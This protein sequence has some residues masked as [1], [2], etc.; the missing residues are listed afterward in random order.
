MIT[1][2]FMDYFVEKFKYCYELDSKWNKILFSAENG[3]KLVDLFFER[4]KEF[5]NAFS[6]NEELIEDLKANI[7]DDL[8]SDEANILYDSLMSL[9]Y[10]GYDDF[11]VLEIVFQPLVNYY[12][13]KLNLNKLIPLLHAYAY[14]ESR[15]YLES[16][17]T[18][19]LD[20][21]RY[22]YEIFSFQSQYDKITDRLSRLCFFKAYFNILASSLDLLKTDSMKYF[23]IRKRALGFWN[24]KI[25]QKLDGNDPEFS[26]F[27]DKIT[28]SIF[29]IDV[30]EKL[31]KTALDIIRVSLKEYDLSKKEN[32]YLSDSLNSIR[33]KL[34][35]YDKKISLM[36]FMDK[37]IIL[38]ENNYKLFLNNYESN[39]DAIDY[40]EACDGAIRDITAYYDDGLPNELKDKIIE[41]V[42]TYKRLLAKLP[43]T[44]Y[45]VEIN[46]MVYEFYGECH[47]LL[48]S[49]E[50]KLD[51]ILEDLMHRQAITCIHSNMV[52]NISVD[53][54]E[55]I[56][57]KKPELFIGILD[58][59]N[60][61]EVLNNKDKI[62]DFVSKAAIL[63]DVGKFTCA[64]IINTQNRRLD[65]KEF[66]II[67]SHPK[68]AK[69]LLQDDKDF[70]EFYDV[71]SGHHKYYDGSYGY[72]AEFDNTKSKYRIVIDI[73]S[74]AD[75]TDAATDI[76]G[77]NYANGKLFV[78]L[79]E[80]LKRESGVRYNPDIVNIISDDL[81]LIEKLSD[82]T[83][84]GRVK[85][86]EY[87]YSKYIK[88][89]GD[90]LC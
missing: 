50:D 26:Y 71:M 35:Y 53:I 12:R 75:S 28:A 85:V 4:S 15:F 7:H 18:Y 59:K 90:K 79:L 52:K 13:K 17:I 76:L 6:I 73:V 5:R 23:Q 51:Y 32:P 57:R 48:K 83:T 81:E 64:D 68:N 30:L 19:N 88:S 72:P 34:D 39:E 22:Y 36:E 14:E 44:Y 33:N 49:F 11:V 41:L 40:L 24:S 58:N 46:T 45:P 29:E 20:S 87:V 43:Y 10:D 61:D 70:D 55:C 82:E 3:E 9:Y 63:H 54:A 2:E 27:I 62:I 69:I 65:D 60:I 77:R 67:K 56:I 37:L 74:I 86:Y 66:K 84:N 80:E 1:K 21:L 31:P 42:Y 89:K 16:N 47:K 25:V 8:T 78:D 38:F